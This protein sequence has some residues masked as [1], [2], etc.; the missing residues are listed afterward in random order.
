MKLYL[1]NELGHTRTTQITLYTNDID[2]DSTNPIANASIISNSITLENL[3]FSE[4]KRVPIGVD[5]NNDPIYAEYPV[6]LVRLSESGDT[7]LSFTAENSS[8]VGTE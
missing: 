7:T 3:E 4:I 6:Y 2:A 5:S 1:H 8:D